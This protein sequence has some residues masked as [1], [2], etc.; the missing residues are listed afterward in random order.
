MS[1]PISEAR[2]RTQRYWFRDGL[3]EITLGIIFL[4]IGGWSLAR[5]KTSW[6]WP[7]TL[8]YLLLIVAFIVFVPRVKTAM[9]ERITYPR[10]GY[11]V[12]GGWWG[13]HR[14]ARGMVFALVGL[15]ATGA[16]VYA[17]RAGLADPARMV[18]WLPTMC[19]ILLGAV[20]VY[21]WVRHGL[22]RWVVVGVF[23]VILGIAVSIE[24]PPSQYPLSLAFGIYVIGVGCAFL[25]SGGVTLRN[26]LRTPPP[27]VQET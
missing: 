21:V 2:V 4:L 3:E 8:V 6:F 12:Q 27:S 1:D 25:C 20:S 16:L 5:V 11:V 13:K 18:Q 7:A 9:R 22:L 24:Y 19:G 15:L 26:Y 14:H 17:G 10:S 23:A